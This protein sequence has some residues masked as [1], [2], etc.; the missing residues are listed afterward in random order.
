M[1]LSGNHKEYENRKALA[2]QK[3]YYANTILFL[4]FILGE[5]ISLSEYPGMVFL[6]FL[7]VLWQAFVL[8]YVFSGTGFPKGINVLGILFTIANGFQLQVF[9]PDSANFN[10]HSFTYGTGLIL[11]SALS[12]T[13]LNFFYSILMILYIKIIYVITLYKYGEFQYTYFSLYVFIF[14]G[15]TNSSLLLDFFSGEKKLSSIIEY[16]KNYSSK[17]MNETLPKEF[18]L[19]NATTLYLDITGL[20]NYYSANKS[21]NTLKKL[22]SEF[23]KNFEKG[24]SDTHLT[25]IDDSKG[26]F[27]FVVYENP[28]RSDYSYAVYLA[29]FAIQL[30]DVLDTHCSENKLDFSFRMGMNSGQYIDYEYDPKNATVKIFKSDKIF[31]LAKEMESLGINKEI[32]ATHAT[33]ELLKHEFVLVKRNYTNKEGVELGGYLLQGTKK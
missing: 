7:K 22:L 17:L 28:A 3:M 24:N 29:N 5:S 19:Q 20:Y 33:Y 32:Q 2:F 31:Y 12:L 6:I 4:Y 23:Y 26:H 13:G 10:F 9:A 16:W 21:L 8:Y 15:I 27:Y 14:I 30:R 18:H 11:F 1:I 25:K